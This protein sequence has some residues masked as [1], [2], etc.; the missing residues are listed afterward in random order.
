MK[1]ID[2][3]IIHNVKE[4]LSHA[5]S[6]LEYAELGLN[7]KTEQSYRLVAFHAQQC[8][9]KSLK[10]YLVYHKIDFPYTHNIATIL[11]LCKET[12]DWTDKLQ[13]AKKLTLYAS[14]LRYPGERV[15]VT[16]KEAITAIEIADNVQKVVKKALVDE[17][18][19]LE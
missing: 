2:E 14:T 17:G 6:D 3:R 5:E 7:L 13:D 8:A 16:K 11:A 19:K 18:L 15:K 12:A 1:E 10:A 9:E 4:W